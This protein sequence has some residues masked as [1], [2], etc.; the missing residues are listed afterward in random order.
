MVASAHQFCLSLTL[1]KLTSDLAGT[2]Q[3]KKVLEM[4]LE[5]W[6]QLTFP[7][8]TAPPPPAA[9]TPPVNTECSCLCRTMPTPAGPAPQALEAEV[10]QLQTR[11]KVSG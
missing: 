10:K 11:L 5:Q 2:E 7:Q 4:E 1:Q 9:P 3:Q 6:R 8:Q